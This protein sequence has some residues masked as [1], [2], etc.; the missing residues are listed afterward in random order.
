MLNPIGNS[1]DAALLEKCADLK[2]F[3]CRVLDPVSNVV[4]DLKRWHIFVT[5]FLECLESDGSVPFLSAHRQKFFRRIGDQRD[6]LEKENVGVASKGDLIR[7][8]R[9]DSSEFFAKMFE[10]V[11]RAISRAV[12]LLLLDSR[13]F[14]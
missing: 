3:R 6:I 10:R 9:Q 12:K 8:R 13:G 4:G 5:V 11:R 14:Q 7:Q 1:Q 2:F